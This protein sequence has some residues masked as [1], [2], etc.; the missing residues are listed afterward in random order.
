MKVERGKIMIEHLYFD[1]DKKILS[2][3]NNIF[4][5]H[6]LYCYEIVE[7]YKIVSKYN[8]LKM[9]YQFI[10][11][12]ALP[13]H[14]ILD[15]CYS[16]SNSTICTQLYINIWFK[17]IKDPTHINLLPNNKSCNTKKRIFITNHDLFLNLKNSL[18]KTFEMLYGSEFQNILSERL[19]NRRQ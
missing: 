18:D 7:K 6:T 16:K 3:D 13:T 19:N 12:P 1:N 2:I 15:D 4:P 8:P 9:I 5:Y 14:E 11:A 10:F 17:D